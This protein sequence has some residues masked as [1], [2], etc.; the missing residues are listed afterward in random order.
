MGKMILHIGP[1]G[2][3]YFF[4]DIIRDHLSGDQP[5]F[6]YM[7][8]VNR[9]V[10]YLKKELISDLAPKTVV[11]PKIFTFDGLFRFL[12]QKMPQRKII[13]GRIIRLAILN[14]LY[15]MVNK[16]LEYFR[17]GR[18]RLLIKIDQM[19]AELLEFGIYDVPDLEPPDSCALKYND[20]QK[21]IRV[22]FDHY[23]DTLIDE[24]A[25]PDTVV[26]NL[27][28]AIIQKYLGE[29]P[30]IYVNG[31]GIY[32]PPMIRLLERLKI[33]CDIEI[34]LDFMP[35]FPNLFRHTRDAYEM[36][37]PLADQELE[38]R[39]G[40]PDGIRLFSSILPDS[41]PRSDGQK[42]GLLPGKNPQTEV[43][44]IAAKI[45]QWHLDQVP[46]HQIGVT[47]PNLEAYAPIIRRV[48]RR[49]KIPFNLSTGFAL[50]QSP[51]IL[52]YLQVFEIVLSGFGCTA[53]YKLLIS[54]F[55]GRVIGIDSHL[56]MRLTTK[57][58]CS[59][60]D[61]KLA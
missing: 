16:D 47:F 8:P 28:E 52:A 9:A 55:C 24:Y 38:Y 23:G 46:L 7:L 14:Y 19:L 30:Q 60:S 39:G 50:A 15:Q 22:L 56:F 59:F 49:F 2:P 35:G 31:Y 12:Y 45:R 37:R 17:S 57:S 42:Y 40:D 41:Q 18:G 58:A 43:I 54:P 13:A 10:R 53:F 51:L 21:I 27:D 48:F 25:L 20:F 11:D 5:A 34:K 32:T 26:K 3:Y 36:L 6:L 44:Q 1:V 29:R 4:R 61:R 33:W